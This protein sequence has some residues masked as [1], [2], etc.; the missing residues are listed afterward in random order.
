MQTGRNNIVCHCQCC[1]DLYSEFFMGEDRKRLQL[2]NCCP[3]QVA[4]CPLRGHGRV[5]LLLGSWCRSNGHL[6]LLLPRSYRSGLT[7]QLSLLSAFTLE[8]ESGENVNHRQLLVVV[9]LL[10]L[11][12]FPSRIVLVAHTNSNTGELSLYL[13]ICTDTS[14]LFCIIRTLS[15]G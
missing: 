12:R 5:N 15:F 13:C 9:E 3:Q 14:E 6:L 1:F 2:D 8:V 10:N 11:P 4:H 7:T